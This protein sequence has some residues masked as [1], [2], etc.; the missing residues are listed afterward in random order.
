LEVYRHVVWISSVRSELRTIDTLHT[1]IQ[2]QPGDQ[3]QQQ[4][5]TKSDTDNNT[6]TLAKIQG[7]T[8][9]F[10]LLDT[11]QGSRYHRATGANRF[12]FTMN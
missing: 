2:S 5:A 4:T 11:A 9:C 7:C 3:Q 10:F 1:T 8:D 12:F 6:T